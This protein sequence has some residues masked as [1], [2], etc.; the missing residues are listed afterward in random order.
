M[1]TIW[2]RSKL[3]SESSR[4]KYCLFD[5]RLD[6]N[7]LK[8]SVGPWRRYALTVILFLSLLIEYDESWKVS[9][10]FFPCWYPS[11]TLDKEFPLYKKL[12]TYYVRAQCLPNREEGNHSSNWNESRDVASLPSSLPPCTLQGRATTGGEAAVHHRGNWPWFIGGQSSQRELAQHWQEARQGHAVNISKPTQPAQTP[13]ARTPLLQISCHNA[14][15][16]RC[17]WALGSCAHFPSC[18]F[19]YLC[20]CVLWVTRVRHTQENLPWK[21]TS[22]LLK[23]KK[24]ASQL[25]LH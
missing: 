20:V 4:F 21:M 15:G 6:L 17:V 16:C 8:G 19:L 5:F 12:K 22:R 3:R 10:P 13:T 18:V 1:S 2:W 9:I 25:I 24:K 11:L 7:E 23:L 14:G